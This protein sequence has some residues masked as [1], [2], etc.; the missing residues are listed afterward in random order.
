MAL[1]DPLAALIFSFAALAIMLYKRVSIATTLIS[2]A[3]VMA[4][5]SMP[6]LD[7]IEAIYS[8]TIDQTTITLVM[9]TI[10]IMMLSLFYKETGALN[11]L[12]RSFSDIFRNPKLIVISLPA[13]IGLL[14]VPG[15]ALMSAPLVD[16][17][18]SKIGLKKDEKTYVNIWFRHIIFPIYP[19]SQVL[20]LTAS[21]TNVSLA[22]IILSQIP[23]VTIMLV[24]GYL[25]VLRNV[26]ITSHTFNKR[27]SLSKN[28]QSFFVSFSPILTMI[29]VVIILNVNVAMAAFIGIALLL[30]ITKPSFKIITNTISNTAI[31]KIGL[32]AYGAMLLRT[33]TFESG[34]SNILGQTIAAFNLHEAALLA[35][36]PAALSFFVGSPIGGISLS[37]P[38]LAG[39]LSFTSKSASLLYISAYLGYLAAPIHLCLVLTADY[40]KCPLNKLYKFLA[41]S[42]ALALATSI[43][44]YF[45]Q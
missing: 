7:I 20:I 45:I 41:P 19:M 5:L 4:V 12:S 18:S 32:A 1:L 42:T 27:A 9:V 37:V 14:P 38:I 43:L 44:V 6:P 31:Y 17:E 22:S 2:T 15:G 33:I 30:L 16:T 28:I 29:L 8:T 3:L 35:I 25:A 13:L 40:F 24:I 21:L 39:I 34:A 36:L 26:D 10:G 11:S 23:V